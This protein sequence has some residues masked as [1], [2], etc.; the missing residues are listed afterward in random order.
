MHRF[1]SG[2]RTQSTTRS[3]NGGNV[4]QSTGREDAVQNAQHKTEIAERQHTNRMSDAN[5]STRPTE[6]TLSDF[7][8]GRAT[9]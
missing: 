3:S 8:A 2:P 7:Q 1:E 9:Y 5:T 4:A 6:V